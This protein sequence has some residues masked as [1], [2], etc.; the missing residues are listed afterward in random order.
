MKVGD[1][2]RCE[3][4]KHAPWPY[5]AETAVDENS[6]PIYKRR[7]PDNGGSSFVNSQGL[8]VTNQWVVTYNKTILL[9]WQGHANLKMVTSVINV[10]YI[11][12]YEF[13]GENSYLN[14]YWAVH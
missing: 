10:K 2:T 5:A 14:M 3:C 1:S 11:F 13:K 8:I 9:L 12:K 7:D 4:S 6:F